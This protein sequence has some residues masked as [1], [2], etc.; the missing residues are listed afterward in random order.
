MLWL[1]VVGPDPDPA[2]ATA[3]AQQPHIPASLYFGSRWLARTRSQFRRASLKA[4]PIPFVSAS[5]EIRKCHP[6]R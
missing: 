5:S 1:E 3:T 2:Y 4:S 6:Q